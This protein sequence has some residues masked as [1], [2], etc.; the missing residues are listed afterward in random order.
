MW[1]S[2]VV[3]VA[4]VVAVAVVVVVAVHYWDGNLIP[5]LIRQVANKVLAEF[6]NVY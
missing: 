4:V 6:L 1:S 5:A 2:R 3:G